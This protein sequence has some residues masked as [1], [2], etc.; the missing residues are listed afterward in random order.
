[1]KSNNVALTTDWFN[2]S[3]KHIFNDELRNSAIIKRDE[4]NEKIKKSII[5]M[6]PSFEWYNKNNPCP[7]CAINK[8][9][10]WDTVHYNCKLCHTHSCDILLKFNADYEEFRK[11]LKTI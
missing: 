7:T 1:M 8:R 10:H 6:Q 2:F 5:D 4:D 3:A 11:N 9:D